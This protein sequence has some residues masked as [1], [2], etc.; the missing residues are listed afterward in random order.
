MH[1]AGWVP[2]FAGY[3]YTLFEWMTL[4]HGSCG[5]GIWTK[6]G[7]RTTLTHGTWAGWVNSFCWLYIYVL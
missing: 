1:G 4:T 7:N 2:D 6:E 3:I 5:T